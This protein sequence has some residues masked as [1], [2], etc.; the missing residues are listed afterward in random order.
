[1]KRLTMMLLLVALAITA[2][3]FAGVGAAAAEVNAVTPSTNDINT[4]SGWANVQQLSR[5]PEPQ[6]S[7]S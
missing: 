5:A 7:S 1:M 4:T 6:T 3:G 2:T